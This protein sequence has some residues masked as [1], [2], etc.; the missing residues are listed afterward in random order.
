MVVF[1]LLEDSV[2]SEKAEMIHAEGVG[3]NYPNVSQVKFPLCVPHESPVITYFFPATLSTFSD[4]RIITAYQ[5]NK[6]TSDRNEDNNQNSC[7][8]TTQLVFQ[9]INEQ[10]NVI[11]PAKCSWT[12]P[13]MTSS[14]IF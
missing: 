14:A 10:I 6:M 13:L 1:V 7:L 3:W 9:Q 2:L 5:K 12:I 8:L 4:C 11:N